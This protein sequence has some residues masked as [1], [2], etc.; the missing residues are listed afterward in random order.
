MEDKSRG[1]SYEKFSPVSSLRS[2]HPSIHPKLKKKK[3]KSKIS[4]LFLSFFFSFSI[5]RTNIRSHL[6][7]KNTENR[8]HLSLSDQLSRYS[9]FDRV[10]ADLDR[11]ADRAEP[12]RG[13]IRTI[14][15]DRVPFRILFFS[16]TSRRW[17]T[18]DQRRIRRH[19]NHSKTQL[20]L[21]QQRLP[22]P[23]CRCS[24]HEEC[25]ERS[26]SWT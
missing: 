17:L 2:I 15:R 4:N 7:A 14:V 6:Y 9:A 18:T 19:S 3:N 24:L 20:N 8:S 13:I 26:G 11:E 12:W 10:S 21:G 1:R 23:P 5:Q 16:A 22:P 25:G